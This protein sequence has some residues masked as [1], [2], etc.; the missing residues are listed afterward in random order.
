MRTMFSLSGEAHELRVDNTGTF[1]DDMPLAYVMKREDDFSIRFR[2]L[3]MV[4]GLRDLLK[5]DIQ[6]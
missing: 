2:A 6:K 5:E 4:R 1:V 3:L